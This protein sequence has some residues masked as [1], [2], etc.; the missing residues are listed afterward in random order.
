M[1]EYT[2]KIYYLG[3]PWLTRETKRLTFLL[4]NMLRCDKIYL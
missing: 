2:E 1:I 3:I 4:T